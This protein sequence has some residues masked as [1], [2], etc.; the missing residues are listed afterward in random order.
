MFFIIPPEKKPS[1]IN[2]LINQSVKLIDFNFDFEGVK[3]AVY[4]N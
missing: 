3:V 4:D 1:A 2:A